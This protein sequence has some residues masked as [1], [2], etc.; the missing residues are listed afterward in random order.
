MAWSPRGLEITSNTGKAEIASH[1]KGG[2]VSGAEIY[3]AAENSLIAHLVA[4]GSHNNAKRGRK[5]AA[6]ALRAA[7]K[8]R[9][10]EQARWLVRHCSFITGQLPIRERGA[11]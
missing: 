2:G 11:A 5:L 7:R 1:G 9:G 8:H 6:V 4:F 10:R 3:R